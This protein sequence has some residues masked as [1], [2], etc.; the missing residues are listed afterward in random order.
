M[1]QSTVNMAYFPTDGKKATKHCFNSYFANKL[2]T[3]KKSVAYLKYS[4]ALCSSLSTPLPENTQMQDH[5]TANFEKGHFQSWK[6]ELSQLH[7]NNFTISTVWGTYPAGNTAN[8]MAS[9]KNRI[10]STTMKL[11]KSLAKPVMRQNISNCLVLPPEVVMH[12]AFNVILW[13]SADIMRPISG[14][15]TEQHVCNRIWDLAAVD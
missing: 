10:S 6:R 13:T 7:F 14:A 1:R 12:D 4:M 8:W 9:W 3:S 5:Q 2:S 11:R 15:R